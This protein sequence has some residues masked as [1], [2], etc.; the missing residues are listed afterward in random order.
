MHE[1]GCSGLVHGDDPEGLLEHGNI[2]FA[3]P[4]MASFLVFLFVAVCFFIHG[5][6]IL[7]MQ[8]WFILYVSLVKL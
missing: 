7:L 8:S 4:V 1:T 2:L 3:T 5:Y 6:F